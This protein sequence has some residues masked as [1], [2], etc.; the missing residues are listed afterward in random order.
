MEQLAE[1][2][3]RAHSRSAIDLDGEAARAREP[4]PPISQNALSPTLFY[5]PPP[6]KLSSNTVPPPFTPPEKVVP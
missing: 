5:C 1:T 3:F 6:G 4:G 2:E